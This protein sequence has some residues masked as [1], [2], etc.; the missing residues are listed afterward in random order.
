MLRLGILLSSMDNN[1]A[2]LHQFFLE[3]GA[4]WSLNEANVE[5]IQRII[6]QMEAQ[7]IELVKKICVYIVTNKMMDWPEDEIVATLKKAQL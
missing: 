2:R 5:K 6:R 4:E 1:T 3:F 7:E